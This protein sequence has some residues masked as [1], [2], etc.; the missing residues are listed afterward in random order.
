MKPEPV[1]KDM[2]R[3]A[4]KDK[5]LS[6]DDVKIATGY[7]GLHPYLNKGGSIRNDWLLK[8]QAFLELEF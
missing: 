7:K 2:I 6:Y 1:I 3:K 5:G 8:I 4:M